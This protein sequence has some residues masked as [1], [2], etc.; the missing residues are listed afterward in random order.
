MNLKDCPAAVQKAFKEK[1]GDGK[2][3]KVEKATEEKATVYEAEI[4]T[5]DGKDLEVVVTPEGALVATEL[6]VEL[7]ACPEAVQKTIKEKAADGQIKGIEKVTTAKGAIT[8]T[9]EIKPAKGD[10]MDLEVSEKGKVIKFE[11]DND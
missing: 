4:K 5:K 8:Y 1:A 10:M 11:K 2:I 3:G 9:A 7:S 6:K